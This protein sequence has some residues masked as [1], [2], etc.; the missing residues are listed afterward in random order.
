MIFM[1]A[2]ILLIMIGLYAV[3]VKRNVIKIVIGLSIMN[4]GINL[5][6]ISMGFVKGGEAPIIY[7]KDFFKPGTLLVDPSK[8]VDPLPQALVLT[9]IVI[10][11]GV[12]AMALSLI[13][14]MHSKKESLEIDDFKELK[15]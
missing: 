2:S 6:I 11:V 1:I 8:I 4:S 12:T 13:I 9:A 5:L 14:R 15:W 7:L 3:L 10:G